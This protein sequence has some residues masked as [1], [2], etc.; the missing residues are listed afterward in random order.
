MLQYVSSYGFLLKQVDEPSKDVS[1]L[2]T[3]AR[4]SRTIID[5][6]TSAI[7]SKHVEEKGKTGNFKLLC[8]LIAILVAIF[9]ALAVYF[10]SEKQVM[11]GF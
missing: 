3:A 5:G 11:F 7:P 2:R 8:M 1:L 4:P 6:G 10:L 9:S